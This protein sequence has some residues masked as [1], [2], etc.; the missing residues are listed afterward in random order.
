MPTTAYHPL[1]KFK[2]QM[3]DFYKISQHLGLA[4]PFY[5]K[6]KRSQQYMRIITTE[7]TTKNNA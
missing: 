3:K 6:E 5:E 7:T 1:R 2:Y 4:L